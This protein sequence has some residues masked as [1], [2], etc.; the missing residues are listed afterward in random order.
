MT[1][2]L[3]TILASFLVLILIFV[4]L[5]RVFPA[6]PGQPIRRPA[7]FVDL[8]FLFGQYLVF[9]GLTL[10]ALHLVHAAV[11]PLSLKT[12]FTGLPLWAAV[13]LAVSLGDLITYWFHRACHQYEF[14]WRFHAVH[15]SSEHL[16][17][18]AAN[19]EHPLD[20]IVTQTCINLPGML[21]GV[22]FELLGGLIVFRGLWAISIHSNLRLPLGPLRVLFGASDLHHWHHARVARTRHNFANLAPYL[23]LLFGTYHRP[24]GPETYPLGIP[25]A[26]PRGYLAQ[27]A[28][29][30]RRTPP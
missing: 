21:L 14:L 13:I 26:W 15:H 29:P 12:A 10:A 30:F 22:P 25:E 23:D 16:D 7:L 17:W 4:P 19:R 9:S 1:P 3:S 27:L 24:R 2:D 20:G 28:R 5:E 8:T 11:L 18:V 6:R